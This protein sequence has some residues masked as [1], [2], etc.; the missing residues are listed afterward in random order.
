MGLISN[1]TWLFIF[2]IFLFQYSN[3]RLCLLAEAPTKKILTTFGQLVAKLMLVSAHLAMCCPVSL[4]LISSRV[5][6]FF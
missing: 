5:L 1:T 3:L 4:V 2:P 6:G